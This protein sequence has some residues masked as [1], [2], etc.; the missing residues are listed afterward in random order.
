MTA[1]CCVCG[2][3]IEPD[4]IVRF[5]VTYWNSVRKPVCQVHT[6]EELRGYQLAEAMACQTIDADCN[7]CKHFLCGPRV[8][9]QIDWTPRIE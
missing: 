9:P 3:E 6:A 7:D 4:D 8:P 5:Y 1:S 2:A